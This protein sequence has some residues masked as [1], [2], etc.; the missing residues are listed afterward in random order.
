MARS[1]SEG[2]ARTTVGASRSSATQG[3]GGIRRIQNPMVSGGFSRLEAEA[4]G[5]FLRG[6]PEEVPAGALAVA[7]TRATEGRG[8]AGSGEAEG[9]EVATS[10][11]G[12]GCCGREDALA[13]VRWPSQKAPVSS[14]TARNTARLLFREEP[15]GLAERDAPEDRAG[16]EAGEAGRGGGLLLAGFVR[17]ALGGQERTGGTIFFLLVVGGFGDAQAR[18]REVQR[19]GQLVDQVRGVLE[20]LR[21]LARRGLAPPRFQGRGQIGAKLEDIRRRRGLDEEH[22]LADAVRGKGALPGE[23]LEHVSV[24]GMTS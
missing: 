16:V 24:H 3:A 17:V 21:R 13:P 14:P 19:P 12:R 8:G 23:H 22:E 11:V 2:C 4:E 7:T 5:R 9:A 18:R 15:W 6:A 20:P 10:A 1:A